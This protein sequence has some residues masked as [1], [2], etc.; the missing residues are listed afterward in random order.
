MGPCNRRNYLAVE[1]LIIQKTDMLSLTIH[2][3]EEVV[4][5]VP[6]KILRLCAAFLRQGRAMKGTVTGTR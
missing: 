4:G 1:S 3:S 2:K 6:R 5:H